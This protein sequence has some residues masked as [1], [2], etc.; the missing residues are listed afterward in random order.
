MACNRRYTAFEALDLIL[1]RT[2][3]PACPRRGGAS[4]QTRLRCRPRQRCRSGDS[5]EALHGVGRCATSQVAHAGDDD[6]HHDDDDD[7]DEEEEEVE[8]GDRTPRGP[9]GRPRAARAQWRHCRVLAR[10]LNAQRVSGRPLCDISLRMGGHVAHAHRGLLAAVSPYF[11]AMFAGNVVAVTVLVIVVVGGVGGNGDG[12][13]GA[14]GGVAG[15]A[16]GGTGSGVGGGIGG[17]GGGAGGAGGGVGGG[18][19][20]NNTAGRKRA[21]LAKYWCQ[22]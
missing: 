10:R 11:R 5:T 18:G 9:R 15:G 3:D 14:G 21:F 12:A 19:S 22:K 4:S 6:E 1:D 20:D 2:Y 13:G 7:D 16:G 17:V 8:S